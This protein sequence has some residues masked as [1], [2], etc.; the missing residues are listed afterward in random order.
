M[1]KQVKMPQCRNRFLKSRAKLRVRVSATLCLGSAVAVLYH[2]RGNFRS[3]KFL[4]L[5]T[6]T[7]FSRFYFHGSMILFSQIKVLVESL[8]L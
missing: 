2:T 7:R 1:L 3:M 6:K 8:L 4:R 5:H